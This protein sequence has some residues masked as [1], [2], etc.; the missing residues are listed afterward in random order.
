MQDNISYHIAEVHTSVGSASADYLKAEKRFNYTTPKSFL[1]LVG[2]YKS[3]LLSKK[4]ELSSSIRRLDIG[5]DTLMR[6]NKD[7][8]ILAEFLIEKKKEV[9]AKKAA[10]DALLEEMGKGM[11]VYVYEEIY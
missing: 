5:L 4:T 7:V 8:D 1:E 10:T 2:F 3:L 11:H 9:E 6:T